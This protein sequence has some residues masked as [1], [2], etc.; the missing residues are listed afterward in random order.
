MIPSFRGEVPR[1]VWPDWCCLR[2]IVAVKMLSIH[3]RA[4][5]Q[6]K[7][8]LKI[9]EFVRISFYTHIYT[10]TH[11]RTH[12]HTHQFVAILAFAL[13]AGFSPTGIVRC[14]SNTGEQTT[15]LLKLQTKYPYNSYT[16]S[17]IANGTSSKTNFDNSIAPGAE[18]FVAWG[19]LSMLY[20]ITAIAVYM[21]FTANESLE[22]VVDFLIYVVC[23]VSCMYSCVRP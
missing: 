11:A 22:K 14:E 2:A 16:L 15:D 1:V 13:V 6:A 20:C 8:F 19:V 23:V 9:I 5:L 21:L 10:H 18:L 17:D 7:G 12:T 4:P 3:W